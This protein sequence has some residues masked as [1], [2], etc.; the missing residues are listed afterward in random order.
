MKTQENWNGSEGQMKPRDALTVS[1]KD[2]KLH[3]CRK[4]HHLV[5]NKKYSSQKPVKESERRSV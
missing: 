2:S 3:V 1:G 5:V 4:Q